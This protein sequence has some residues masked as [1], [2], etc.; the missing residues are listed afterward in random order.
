MTMAATVKGYIEGRGVAYQVITHPASGSSQ[1]LADAAHVDQG[2]IAKAVIL[3]DDA[4]V[5]M[6]VVPGDAWVRLSALQEELGREMELA[7]EAD[8]AARFPDCDAGAIP[9][10]GPAYGVETVLDTALTSLAN[11]YFES[12]DHRT[13]IRVAG[14]DFLDLLDGVRRGYYCHED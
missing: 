12:G 6:A 7:E 9:P 1:E 5:V 2:H 14:E 3:K 11:V 8:A 10:L 13:L 4:G